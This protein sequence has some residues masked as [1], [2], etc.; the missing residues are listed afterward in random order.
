M[1]LSLHTLKPAHGSAKRP[2]IIG[3]GHGSGKGKTAGRGTKGQASRSGVSGLKLQ[4]FRA[5]MLSMPKSRGFV[6]Q[7]A[8]AVTVTLSALATA[9]PQESKVNVESLKAKNLLQQGDSS[10]KIV[11]TGSI[12]VPLHI[13]GIK[14]SEGAKAA[15]EKAGGSVAPMR[16]KKMK[17]VAKAKR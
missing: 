13:F 11:S 15:I 2:F 5:L 8:K 3:R 14:V 6:S 10:A 1:I 7:H 16:V 17:K 4:G 9:Y 12:K